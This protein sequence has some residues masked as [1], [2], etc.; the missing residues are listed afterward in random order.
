VAWLSRYADDH[1]A[2]ADI[3]R[4]DCACANRG[5]GTNMQSRKDTASNAHQHAIAMR[6][7]ERVSADVANRH[8]S[9][10]NAAWSDMA[11][12]SN[13]AFMLDDGA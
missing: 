8:V 5:P 13:I 2:I 1:R 3:S 4:Y 12:G 9:S 7:I 11:V 10:E 6:G